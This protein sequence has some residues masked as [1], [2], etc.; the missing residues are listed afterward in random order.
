[1]ISKNSLRLRITF[2]ST[3]MVVFV[4]IILTVISLYNLNMNIVMPTKLEYNQINNKAAVPIGINSV[5]ENKNNTS[6]GAMAITSENL[7]NFKMLA[8]QFMIIVIVIGSC[9][10]YYILGKML[11]P[12]KDLSQQIEVINEKNL[13]TRIIGFDK[14]EELNQISKS[15]NIMLDKLDNAFENQKRF[16]SDAAHEL[17]TPL[18]V[19]KSNIEVLQMEEC[20][21]EEDYKHVLNIFEKQT[22]RMISL[23]DSLFII[24]TNREYK[25]NDNI[26][27]DNMV[28]EILKDLSYQII[29][30]NIT[31]SVE[32]SNIYFKGNK[33][34]M[35]HAIANLIENAIKYNN[36][37][38]YID[39]ISKKSSE[40]SIIQIKD[41]GI[42]ISD[43]KAND[44]FKPFYR[45][46][47][48]RSRKIGGA[49]LGL[50]ITKD[51]INKH[52]FEIEYMKNIDKGSIFEIK[53][54]S[55]KI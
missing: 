48:S 29:E 25:L 47:K 5:K 54:K 19:L 12:V 53:I 6:P 24:S 1:M 32:K 41:S 52:D 11:A 46:D 35:M 55:D 13:S 36:K 49:G 51:I 31:V 14:I 38:G 26:N 37:N 40:Y 33:V 39:I 34:M 28:D 50:A 23:V 44:I 21:T 22:Q 43:E 7:N 20:P 2:I 4:S 9:I 45:C 42:G 3:I 18:T 30:K 16:S 15:F 17:K 27:F 10:I 8:I